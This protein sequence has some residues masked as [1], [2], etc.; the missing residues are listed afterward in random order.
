MLVY[1][2]LPYFHILIFSVPH[3]TRLPLVP[4]SDL[5]ISKQASKT[6]LCLLDCPIWKP[7]ACLL[8]CWPQNHVCLLACLL[9]ACQD[10]IELEVL[11]KIRHGSAQQQYLAHEASPPSINCS[12]CLF[13]WL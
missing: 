7:F 8:A 12:I 5:L 2:T 6:P 4:W 3:V 1:L 11:W 9:I 13:A 10:S